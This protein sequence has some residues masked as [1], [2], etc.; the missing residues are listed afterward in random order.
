M[1]RSLKKAYPGKKKS[2]VMEDNDP[3][4][5]KS[6]K[7][8][9]AKRDTGIVTDDLP[10]R[11]PDLNVL[12][13]SLWHTINMK[14]RRQEASFPDDLTETAEEYKARLR[15]TA[16]GLPATQVSRA[17]GD[18]VRRCNALWDRRGRLFTE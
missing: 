5:F 15:K 12:D 3:T 9:A 13:Y 18:M 16:M 1:N 11:S 4:G 14:M 10:P 2:T 8:R 6:S 7:A 17:V